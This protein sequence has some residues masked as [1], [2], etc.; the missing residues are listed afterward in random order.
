MT[1][2]TKDGCKTTCKTDSFCNK[3][4]NRC[5]LKRNQKTDKDKNGTRSNESKKLAA[6]VMRAEKRKKQQ[7]TMRGRDDDVV[8]KT[9]Q[10]ARAKM[11]REK[12]LAKKKNNPQ[13]TQKKKGLLGG[14]FGMM[15]PWNNK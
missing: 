10:K 13:P 11:T 2:A 15:N 12:N 9:L 7:S 5:N 1:P 4:T 14:V 6:Q 3:N 8:A